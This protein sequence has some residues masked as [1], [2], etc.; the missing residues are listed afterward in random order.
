M[1]SRELIDSINI[2]TIRINNDDKMYD[3]YEL[4]NIVV[5]YKKYKIELTTLKWPY[6]KT[7]EI[8]NI[9]LI[10][11][12]TKI[13]CEY[14]EDKY[15]FTFSLGQYCNR[16]E[17]YFFSDTIIYNFFQSWDGDGCNLFLY[18]ITCPVE[19][20]YMQKST[21]IE[22]RYGCSCKE[23]HLMIQMRINTSNNKIH[24]YNQP[25]NELEKISLMCKLFRFLL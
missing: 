5:L 3:L 10:P 24:D 17:I 21:Y 23:K 14:M 11:D 19:Y 16:T 6:D 7:I 15:N 22:I 8:I 1:E 18:C 9:F 25:D 2:T 4:K 12:L 20:K 13:V